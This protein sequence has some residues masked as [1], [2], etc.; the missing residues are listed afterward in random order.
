MSTVNATSLVTPT[1]PDLRAVEGKSL[2]RRLLGS[3]ATWVFLIDIVLVIVFGVVSTSNVF[4][5]LTSVQSL[6]LGGTQALLLALG[7]AMLLGAGVFDLS[8]GANLV[9]SSVVG[10]LTIRAIAGPFNA[11]NDYQNLGL[12]ILLGFIAS[13]AT[14]T[15]FGLFNG[16][17]V[18]TFDINPLI[19]TLGTT[20]IG[21]GLALLLSNGGNISGLPNQL[22]TSIGLNMVGGVIP[23][24]AL[25]ALALA[26]VVWFLLKYTRFGLRSLAMGSSRTSAERAGVKVKRQTMALTAIAGS[27]AGVAGFVDIARFGSTASTG[28]TQDALN[29][30]TAVIIGGTLLEGGRVSIIGAVWGT[31]LSVVLT[32]GLIIIGVAPFYQLIAVGAVLIVAISIDRYRSKRQKA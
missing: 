5:S 21:T 15:I 27:L 25:V 17:I 8:L 4:W 10:A 18:S 32:S 26:V 22:Q 7:L 31:I 30:V 9:L 14:G 11:A 19:A 29:A 12:A 13:L 6:M 16:F 2:I 3:T 28:H 24:P 23:L 20:G 1:D